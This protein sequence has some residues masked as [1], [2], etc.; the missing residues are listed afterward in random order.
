MVSGGSCSVLAK[1]DGNSL[2]KEL[3][4]LL[5]DEEAERFTDEANLSEY[6]LSGFRPLWFELQKKTARL[7]RWLPQ[8]QLDVVKAAAET[9]GNPDTRLVRQ[10]IEQ[11]MRGL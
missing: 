5:T 9:R 8:G 7:E 2:L 6:D 10:F 4:P 1:S 3:P 11:E